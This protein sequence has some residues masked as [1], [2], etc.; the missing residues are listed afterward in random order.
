MRHVARLHPEPAGLDVV[1][2][3]GQHSVNGLIMGH[4]FMTHRPNLRDVLH[5]TSDQRQVFPDR[6]ARNG[7]GDW[8]H[9]ATNLIW[10]LG[11]QIEH[12]DVARPAIHVQHQHGLRPRR[13]TAMCT[14]PQRIQ[15]S[16]RRHTAATHSQQA[17]A[18]DTLC[19]L[20][21]PAVEHGDN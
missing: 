5:L 13:A 11:F 15:Q 10:S 4:V 20:K 9:G 12:V 1:S 2:I 21:Q 19:F 8:G 18:I 14:G 6:N 16:P 17:A 3:S 7:R